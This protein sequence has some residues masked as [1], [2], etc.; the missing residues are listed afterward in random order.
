MAQDAAVEASEGREEVAPVAEQA[1]SPRPQLLGPP[2]PRLRKLPLPWGPRGA[3][4]AAARDGGRVRC[5]VSRRRRWPPAVRASGV[6]Q[7]PCKCGRDERGR[8][9]CDRRCVAP[10]LYASQC[11]ACSSLFFF[12][13]FFFFFV[14]S[15][16]PLDSRP[17]RGDSVAAA[18][19]RGRG[20]ARLGGR[21][22]RRR[23]LRE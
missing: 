5:A 12:F 20:G 6:P 18:N 3:A 15:R 14:L 21:P 11:V 10:F 4:V 19:A 23:G 13:F 16:G 22:S 2:Q 9:R 17:R 7:S 8:K 1:P